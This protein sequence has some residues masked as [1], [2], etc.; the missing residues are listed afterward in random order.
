M[1]IAN[2]KLIAS[3]K[4]L[5]LLELKSFDR[6]LQSPWCNSNKKAH[7][8]FQL[9]KKAYPDFL[10]TNL[11]RTELF[12]Q[13]YPTKKYNDR[14]LRNLMADLNKQTLQFLIHEAL[15]QEEVLPKILLAKVYERRHATERL[16]KLAAQ[17]N[18]D[19]EAKKNKAWEE[20]LYHCLL[21]DL[22]YYLPETTNRW[23]AANH[24]LHKADANLDQ[25]YLLGKWRYRSEFVE[26]TVA[27]REEETELIELEVLQQIAAQHSMPVLKLYEQKLLEGKEMTEVQFDDLQ[28]KLFKQLDILSFKDQKILYYYLLNM[29]IRICL[30]GKSHLFEK[31]FKLYQVGI[32]KQLIIH[33][34]RIS[35]KTYTNIV[36][37][38]NNLQ[39]FGYVQVF[40]ESQTVLLKKEKQLDGQIW[41]KA[42]WHFNQQDFR[43]AIDLLWSHKFV[44]PLFE[45]QGRFLLLQAYFE[46]LR[47]DDTYLDLFLAYVEAYKKFVQRDKNL[48]DQRKKAYLLFIKYTAKL[49]DLVMQKEKRRTVY[50]QVLQNIDQEELMQG[51]PWL[52]TVLEGMINEAT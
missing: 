31:L 29:L 13:L 47:N 49:A 5:S 35:D 32:E 3:L 33:F 9:L 51:K 39:Q 28:E 21:N 1:D 30:R 40:I 4:L 25:F 27:L 20:Y 34:D 44:T 45:I 8:L 19:L 38:G 22:L 15:K 10:P 18:K 52:N 46:A 2:S 41:A 23:K 42:H 17:L 11:L 12:Q 26:R 50:Q 36:T 37:L 43:T 6:W 24:P 16:L 14:W 7:Q 48:A